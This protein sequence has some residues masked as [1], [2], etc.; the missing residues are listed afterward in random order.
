MKV[1]TEQIE[2]TINKQ[3]HPIYIISGDETLLVQEASDAI[4][5]I[6]PSKGIDERLRFVADAQFD[7]QEVIQENQALSLFSSQRLFDIQIDKLSEKHTKALTQLGNELSTDNIILLTL[8]KL[9]G[10][11]QKTKWFTKLESQGVFVQIWP[12]GSNR[13]GQWLQK[14]AT[15]LELSLTRDAA[16][17]ICERNEGNLLA[18]S[19]ELEK[20]VLTHAPGSKIDEQMIADSVSD[21]S[22]YSVYDLSDRILMGKVK[23]SLHCLQQLSAEGVDNN[24][25]LWLLNREIQTLDKLVQASTSMP[26]RQA[27]QKQ[28]IWDKRIPF[29][30]SALS[31]HNINTLNYMQR[32]M[33]LVDQ[34]IKGL[35]AL[36]I[37]TGM[38]NLVMMFCGVKAVQ[39]ELDIES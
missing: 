27:C 26:V 28:R 36:D 34:T 4:R 35:H 25:L 16:A 20:L 7:W 14:R 8:P 22:R 1:K 18:L 11:S 19:Q 3:I 5:R 21:S 37:D 39:T 30:E 24:I 23:E 12:V 2:Q 33:A 29:Y 17:L 6:L 15:S 31:R 9:D 13:L 38:R 32:Y 10:R